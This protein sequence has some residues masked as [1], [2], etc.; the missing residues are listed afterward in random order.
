V[1]QAQT[2]YIT[3]NSDQW[4]KW[5]DEHCYWTIPI[6]HEEF[7]AAKAGNYSLYITP[8][9]PIPKNWLGEVKGQSVLALASA[10]GQQCPI[11]VALGADVTVFDNSQ[12]QLNTENIVADREGYSIRIIKGDM[13][14]ILPFSNECFD[15]II[16]PVSNSYIKD[17]HLLWSECF[18]VLKRGGCL[19]TGFANPDVYMFDLPLT[20]E[21]CV[22]YKLP[23]DPLRDLNSRDYTT[24]TQKDGVQ[25][26]HTLEE[27][28]GGQIETGFLIS[29]FYEDKHPTN[30]P[31]GYDTYIGAIASKLTE[32]TAIYYATKSI[33]A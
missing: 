14:N 6:S 16:N 3:K 2:D 5:V 9:R 28:I 24:I 10:G 12:K 13:S 7:V 25:F 29:G 18:R 21:L 11:L 33:K 17:V 20:T 26:S 19:I 8:Q 4:D 30:D 1:G 27:Q 31:A 22:K 23:F 15:I 32:Y